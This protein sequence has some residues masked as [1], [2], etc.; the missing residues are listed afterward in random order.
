[1]S[2]RPLIGAFAE[3]IK[4][5]IG[6]NRREAVGI[7]EID[8]VVAEAGAQLITFLSRSAS[9]GKQACVVDAGQRRGFAM[10]ADGLD[11]R[12]FGQ[13]RA[14]DVLVALAMKAE[15]MERDRNGGLR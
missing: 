8:D 14:H 11:V 9:H 6:Q 12:G 5:E 15:I 7:V 2:Y 4:I 13:E 3:Q 10:L 1:M